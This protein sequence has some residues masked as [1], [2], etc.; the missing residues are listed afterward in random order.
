MDQD[1]RELERRWLESGDEADQHAWLCARL[2]QGW[3]DEVASDM[4]AIEQAVREVGFDSDDVLVSCRV[5]WQTEGAEPRDR[6]ASLSG[7]SG[8][9]PAPEPQRNLDFVLDVERL[10]ALYPHR[11]YDTNEVAWRFMDL[12]RGGTHWINYTEFQSATSRGRSVWP[13]SADVPDDWECSHSGAY[14]AVL[15][16]LVGYVAVT[17]RDSL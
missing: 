1:L 4:Q 9:A 5:D 13:F 6:L 14:G 12:F 17:A 2:R 8:W 15:G 11:D 7:H 16:P 3:G 10:A